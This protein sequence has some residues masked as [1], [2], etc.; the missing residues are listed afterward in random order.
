LFLGSRRDRSIDVTYRDN[1][2]Q[3]NFSLFSSNLEISR[4]STASAV[5]PCCRKCRR[6]KIISII[7]DDLEPFAGTF[8]S[9]ER[10]ML[11]RKSK[12]DCCTINLYKKIKTSHT[13]GK[14]RLPRIANAKPRMEISIA[15]SSDGRGPPAAA[16]AF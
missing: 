11:A 12:I 8:D 7:F 16:Q 2:L 14:R 10:T 4:Y 15:R 3:I 6:R 9:T 1:S 5:H 13:S